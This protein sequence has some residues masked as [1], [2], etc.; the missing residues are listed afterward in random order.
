MTGTKYLLNEWGVGDVDKGHESS[1]QIILGGA[2][3]RVVFLEVEYQT[4]ETWCGLLQSPSPPTAT[5]QMLRH[6][7]HPKSIGVRK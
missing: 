5:L 1:W 6:T 3:T 4:P 7:I 2:E